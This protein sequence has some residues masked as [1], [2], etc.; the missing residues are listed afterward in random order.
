METEIEM[1]G[2]GDPDTLTWINVGTISLMVEVVAGGVGERQK[3]REK[4]RGRKMRKEMTPWLIDPCITLSG[5]E[6]RGVR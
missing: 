5:K 4:I 3:K 1:R 6:G 2:T